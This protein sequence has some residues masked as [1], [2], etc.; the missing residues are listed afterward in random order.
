MMRVSSSQGAQ[1][2]L[3]FCMSRRPS[4]Q[5]GSLWCTCSRSLPRTIAFQDS[6]RTGYRHSEPALGTRRSLSWQ[7]L[8]CWRFLSLYFRLRTCIASLALISC[9]V[10]LLP[11]LTQDHDQAERSPFLA[12]LYATWW[13]GT[14]LGTWF[15]ITESSRAAHRPPIQS[16]HI[17]CSPSTCCN[18][19]PTSWLTDRGRRRSHS[20]GRMNRC[21][22]G[23]PLKIASFRHEWSDRARRA[24]SL[25]RS[26]LLQQF[27][28][29]CSG[30]SS[31]KLWLCRWRG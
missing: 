21:R 24:S 12:L 25:N 15:C 27:E 30:S 5:E 9:F 19:H 16:L 31:W 17:F 13:P 28:C 11:L 8:I 10:C 29:F 7:W 18:I 6:W 3:S 14:I 23:A 26:S 2:S 4:W 1:S 22:T 20:R